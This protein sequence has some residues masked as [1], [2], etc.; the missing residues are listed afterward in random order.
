[1]AGLGQNYW[2]VAGLEKPLLDPHDDDVDTQV[3]FPS[4][5]NV[6]IVSI[7]YPINSSALRKEPV[8]L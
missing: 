8:N 4:H 7:R 3:S 1:M 2:R 5:S 6:A